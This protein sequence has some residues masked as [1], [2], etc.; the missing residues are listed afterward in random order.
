MKISVTFFTTFFLLLFAQSHS[1]HA[2]P[3]MF[4]DVETSFV[5]STVDSI[6]LAVKWSFDEFTSGGLIMDYDQNSNFVLEKRELQAILKDFSGELKKHDYFMTILLNNKKQSFSLKNLNIGEKWI[7]SSQVSLGSLT[8]GND[9]KQ[10]KVQT[11]YYTFSVIISTPL[12]KENELNI[13]YLDPTLYSALSA[14]KKMFFPASVT[15]KSNSLITSSCSFK[16]IFL[17]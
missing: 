9:K 12:K 3:H 8:G 15:V 16:A 1:V 17:Q 13:S 10:T 7:K 5:K 14:T 11:V 2:H 4:V 6:E